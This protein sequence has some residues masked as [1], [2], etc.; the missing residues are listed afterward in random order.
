[1]K[2]ELERTGTAPLQLLIVLCELGRKEET[3]GAIEHASFAQIFDEEGGQAAGDYNPG[4][5]L[6]RFTN[7]PTMS[8]PR[9]VRL[10][11][12]LGSVSI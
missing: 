1:V 5:I 3:S 8:E 2:D 9:F 11:R 12:K 6:N 4:I 10:C 7:W